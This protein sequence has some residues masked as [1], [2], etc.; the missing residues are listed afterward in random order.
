MT[1][2][3]SSQKRPWSVA[4]W[5]AIGTVILVA[6]LTGAVSSRWQRARA[7]TADSNRRVASAGA[8]LTDLTDMETGQRGYLLVGEARYLEPYAAASERLRGDLT[9]LRQ[10]APG[11]SREST[12]SEQI[13]ALARHKASELDS[14]IAL[15]R[16]ARHAEAVAIVRTDH[17]KLVMDSVRRAVQVLTQWE[18]EHLRQHALA[19]DRWL[20][21]LHVVLV[22]GTLL[23][24]GVLLYLRRSLLRYED[25]QRAATRELERQLAAIEEQSRALAVG[26][27]SS[28]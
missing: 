5:I 1:A 20:M 13:S 21:A 6:V 12:V 19:E 2:N 15:Q 3:S 28:S 7:L 10:G 25:A 8:V 27:R 24:L 17:G 4:T 11:A 14:T 22:V 9:T 18:R 23:T 26:D 16:T